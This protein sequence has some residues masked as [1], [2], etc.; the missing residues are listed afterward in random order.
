MKLEGGGLRA[1]VSKELPQKDVAFI[2]FAAGGWLDIKSVVSLGCVWTAVCVKPAPLTLRRLRIR[3]FVV[4]AVVLEEMKLE[5]SSFALQRVAG[6][7]L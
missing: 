6:V 5:Q 2:G 1:S 4:D 3:C 7:L